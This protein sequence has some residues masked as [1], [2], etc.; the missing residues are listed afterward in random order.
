MT[1][2]AHHVSVSPRFARSANLERDVTS[3]DPLDGYIVTARAVDVVDRLA[4]RATC[5][6]VGGAW[7]ITGPYGSGKSSLALL[8]DGAF[9][10][11]GEV[12]NKT[13]DLI[14]AAAPDL[15]TKILH[16]HE[17][18]GTIRPGFCRAVATAGREPISHT[19]LRALHLAVIRR[20]G[21]IP[22]PSKFKAAQALID[23][24]SDEASDDP[25]RTGP[26]PSAL[27]AVARCL[28]ESAPL[29]IVIDEFGKNL[30]AVSSSVDSDPYLL[31]QLAE[32][33]QGGDTPIFTLTLQHLSFEDYFT[34][35]GNLEH[36][37][38]AKVQGRFE[39]VPFADSPAETRALISSVF[40]FD[41]ALREQIDTWAASMANAMGRLGFEDLST[42]DAVAKCFPLHPLA[43]AILPELCSRY[44]QN[45]RTLFSFLAGSDASAVPAVLARCEL[46]GTDLLPAIGLSEVYDYFIEGEIAGSPGVHGSRWREIA[47]C[48][49]DAH[50]LSAHEWTLAKSIA[51]LNLVGASGTI[52]ASK[53]LLGQVSKRPAATLRNLEERGLVTYRAFADEYRV[54][55]GSDL[56]VRS[57]VESA[58]ATLAKLPLIEV[59]SRFDPP[60]PVIAARHSA[61][62]DTLRVFTRRY[63]TSSEV[64][65]PLSP[66]SEADGEL[67]LL[68]DSES[69]C[70]AIAEAGLSKPIVAAVPATLAALDSSARNLAAIHQ[71]LELPEVANDWVVRS[72]LGEQLAQAET[73]FHEA[74]ISTFDPQNCA[75]FLLK[76]DCAEPL[77]TGRGTAALSAAADEAYR[78]APRIGNEM[79]NRTALTSQG[80]KARSMLLTGMIERADEV[81]LGFEGYG[82]EVAMY[83]SVLERTGMHRFDSRNDPQGFDKPKEPSLQPAWKVMDEEFRRSRK[84]RVNLNDLFAV[85]MSPPIGMKA[86]V[87]PV[88]ATAGLLAHANEIAIYEHGTF[89]PLLSAELSERMVK[90]PSHFEIKHFAN[91][92]GA[93]RQV[94]DELAARLGVRPTFRKLRVANVLAIVGHLVSR[95]NRLDNYTL[96]TR[97]LPEA[98]KNAREALVTAV[99]PDELLFDA[100]PKALG[101]R[102]V[103]ANTKSY[104]RAQAYADSVGMALEDLTGCFDS[105]LDD[106]YDLL[107]EESGETSRLAVV[108][109][110]A[111]LENEVLDPRIRAFTLALANDGVDTDVDWIK[112]VAMVVTEKAPAEWTDDD[113]ARFRRVMPEHIAAF[114]R[115]VALHAEHRANGG[116]P[117]DA[118]RVTVT[119]ADGSELARLVGIDQSSRQMLEQVLNEALKKLSEITGSQ[120]RA[121]H[122]LLALLGER[123][124]STGSTEEHTGTTEIDL[125]RAEKAHHA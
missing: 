122:A 36:R 105:L 43:A 117:F 93:R 85:L 69:H 110:A 37:E 91:T 113:L 72:E 45:E 20:F 35:D 17:L 48:L 112:A 62:Y 78:L 104:V 50:G 97:N 71:V 2:L 70:P 42:S 33:G 40:D 102:P 120:R 94:I 79:I 125:Q 77:T 38:W 89:K 57:L 106:L 14:G 7:S 46:A 10:E 27:L 119:Q 16:A 23:A 103:P 68:V 109:Q 8:I 115:L 55:Q 58:T 123:M 76:E 121:D 84:R 59:L 22:P 75:W 41:D 114:Q 81:D 53:T 44:G 64:I 15:R 63:A 83:R 96:R 87:I 1:T 11:E 3:V 82:P 25:R 51:I 31:Q 13:L 52:R 29:L 108:G 88:F 80:A 92:T 54:W 124:L 90:N 47:T 18:H 32:A 30:E 24:L 12:R 26:S 65:K 116:G 100:L 111:A 98:T 99:E 86:A 4:T 107:L 49:R 101:F 39:D 9:G 73:L 19:V 6:T 67:L 60:A 56:D 118:L 61:E 74:F 95:V 21:S 5:G 28:A 34:A 66:F